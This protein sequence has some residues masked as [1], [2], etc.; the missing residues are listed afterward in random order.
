MKKILGLLVAMVL[1]LS[2]AAAC[3]EPATDTTPDAPADTS[4]ATDATDSADAD[5][6]APTADGEITGEIRVVWWGGDHRHEITLQVIDMFEEAFPGI[7]VIPEFMGGDAYWDRLATQV[8]GGNAPDVMQFGGNYPDYVNRGALLPLNQFF[9]N[10]I[11]LTYI[12][13]S[14]IDAATIDGLTYGLCLG[15]NMLGIVYNATMLAET[16]LTVPEPGYTWEDFEAFMTELAPLLPSGVFPMADNSGNN[17]NTLGFFGRQQGQNIFTHEGVTRA[18]AETFTNYFTM[19]ENWRSS[20]LIPGAEVAAEFSEDGVD[21]SA[22]VAGR[23]MMTILYSNQL[24][25][26]QDAMTD[27]LGIM[28]LPELFSNAAWVMPSQ[29]FTIFMHS[30]FPEAA[31]TFINFFVNTPEVGL[32]LGNDRG[33]SVNSQVRD[34]K[35]TIATP[36]DLLIYDLYAVAA[37]FTTEMDPN[38]PNDQEFNDGFRRI[39]EQVAFG[40]LTL[41]EAGEAAFQL[42]NDM[43]ARG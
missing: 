18:T 4:S 27:E 41:G 40:V 1:L 10:I 34:A 28:P 3:A 33:I 7:T 14:A 21:S 35:A 29:Y 11:D 37:E 5:T 15:T 43:I 38:V 8:A 39:A 25:G 16:G 20:N 24:V 31:A 26:Y 12:D 17:T 32:I 2:I 42:L 9:G 36:L 30:E 6:Q 23:A 19:W 13:Q 22:L